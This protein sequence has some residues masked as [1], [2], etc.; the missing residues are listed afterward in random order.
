MEEDLLSY[1]SQHERIGVLIICDR[2]V[3][4]RIGVLITCDRLVP[5][6]IGVLI[7]CDG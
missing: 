3:P 4:K 7:I 2:L 5:E 6:R 1:S